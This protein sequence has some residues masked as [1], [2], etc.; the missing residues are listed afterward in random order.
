M[1]KVLFL[2]IAFAFSFA[3]M[4][5]ESQSAY[6][7]LRL[8]ASTHVAALG[9]E[10]ISVI[11]DVPSLGYSNPALY[12]LAPNRSV[13]FSFM[14]YPAGG[15]LLG[16]QA[17]RAF[18][19]RHTLGVGAQMLSYGSVDETDTQ[20][21]AMGS[22]TPSDVVVSLGYAY[23][24]SDYVAG[25]ANFKLIS[26]KYGQYNSVA[27]AV[28]LGL[29]YYDPDNDLSVSAVLSNVGT[30]V[31]SFYEGQK[32]KVP[33]NLQLGFTKGLNNLPVRLSFTLTDLTRWKN[34]Y[35]YTADGNELSFTR[36]ALNHL[37]VGMDIIPVDICYLSLGYNFRRAYE[38]KQAGSSHFAGFSCGAGLNLDR[39]KIGLSYAQYSLGTS[40]VM[41]NLAFRL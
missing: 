21:N 6:T 33:L 7:M 25:G 39:V 11:D 15:K 30:Q 14:T 13:G 5:Q 24:L 35:Y 20:G 38:L 34:N 28:D 19:E 26:S 8:P 2:C 17:A 37:V 1:K 32:D 40:S 22:F 9:G 16:F 12:S 18:G 27:L 3:L 41:A 29:N 36:K 10:N 23:L 4:A 31:K